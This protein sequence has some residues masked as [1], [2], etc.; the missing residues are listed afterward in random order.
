MR[1]PHT[2]PGDR[3]PG[4]I[5]RNDELYLKEA[6]IKLIPF[7]PFDY[8]QESILNF[9]DLGTGLMESVFQVANQFITIT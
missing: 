5:R 6:L 7:M 9:T 3:I 2:I 4:S 1:Y 8:L